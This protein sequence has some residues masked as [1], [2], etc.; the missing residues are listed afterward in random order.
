M[1]ACSK[2]AHERPSDG[3]KSLPALTAT[4]P[5]CA[6]D[7]RDSLCVLISCWGP[8]LAAPAPLDVLVLVLC[9]GEAASC[10]STVHQSPT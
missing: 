8:A 3:L 7:A 1:R 4:A 5:T 9:G 10:R 2:A 6:E